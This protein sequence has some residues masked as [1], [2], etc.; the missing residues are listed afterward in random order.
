L[1]LTH[2]NRRFPVADLETGVV[3]GFVCFNKAFTKVHLFKMRNGKVELIQSVI[4]PPGSLDRL[5][6][7]SRSALSC[8]LRPGAFEESPW[9]AVV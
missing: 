7:R 5:A 3:A 1:V 4:G 2:L 8:R 9:G 6:D